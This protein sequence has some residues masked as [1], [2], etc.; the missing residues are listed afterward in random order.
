MVTSLDINF[1]ELNIEIL[2]GPSGK[3]Y[4][5]ELGAR[6]G[7][8]FIPLALSDATETDLIS[9]NVKFAMDGVV[10][11]YW[12]LPAASNIA[13]FVLHSNSDGEFS[14]VKYS[15]KATS[16]LYREIL[17]VAPGDHVEAFDGAGKALGVSF[18]RFPNTIEMTSFMATINKHLTVEL[19]EAP[20]G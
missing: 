2:L 17:Y 4:F 18:F 16:Y 12:S 14:S 8:N 9:A 13:T 20:N 15:D 6:A 7:G 19:L 3:V 1:G 10:A 11:D 5:I